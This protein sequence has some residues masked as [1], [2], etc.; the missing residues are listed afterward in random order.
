VPE[1]KIGSLYFVGIAHKAPKPPKPPMTSGRVV[2]LTSA[3]IFS[4][5]ALPAL[6]STPA[7]L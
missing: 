3:L 4:T 1:T 2:R 5:K 6:I 7:S